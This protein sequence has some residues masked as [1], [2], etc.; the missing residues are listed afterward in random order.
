MDE[1]DNCKDYSDNRNEK[2]EENIDADDD[3]Y[4]EEDIL[5]W[6][7]KILLITYVLIQFEKRNY[8]L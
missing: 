5:Q 3:Y 1:C 7:F 2:N 4:K 8:S 6:T